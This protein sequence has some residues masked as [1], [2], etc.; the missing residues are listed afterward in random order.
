[1]TASVEIRSASD[2][3]LD[4]LVA[5]LGEREF[6]ADRIDRQHDGQGVL[7]VAWMADRPVGDVFLTFEPEDAPV[8]RHLPGVPQLIHLEVVGSLQR[9]GI[10]IALIR[11][12]EDTARRLGH[13]EITL[14]VGLDNAKA[15]RLYERW[16]YVDWRQG[17]IEVS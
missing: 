2:A 3:D 6:F 9:R 12:A 10:G 7:L 13:Q 4:A 15:R 14:A 8:R 11:A 16:G 1:M 17:T 5:V